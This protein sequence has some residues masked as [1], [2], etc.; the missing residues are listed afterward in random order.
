M[1]KVMVATL[2]TFGLFTAGAQAGYTLEETQACA[3][4]TQFHSCVAQLNE[5]QS[6]TSIDIGYSKEEVAQCGTANDFHMCVD[7]LHV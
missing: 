1:K 6:K 3:N 5:Q 2:M 4:S 7:N